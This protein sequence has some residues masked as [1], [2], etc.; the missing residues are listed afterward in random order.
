MTPILYPLS[1]IT[2]LTLQKVILINPMAQTI[3]DARY[4]AITKQTTTAY[5]L[6]EGGWYKL[7]PFVI[8]AITLVTGL[9][10][11]RKESKYFAENI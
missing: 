9:I 10:Y 2:N 6:F 11:F 5:T 1:L 7:L 8:V 4:V 3:Q